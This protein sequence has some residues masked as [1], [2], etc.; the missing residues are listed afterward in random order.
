MF[1]P[2]FDGNTGRLRLRLVPGGSEFGGAEEVVIARRIQLQIADA[3][4]VYENVVEIP[5]IDVG[6]FVGQDQLQF[7]IG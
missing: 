4:V 7:G 1:T 6:Q 5:K 3:F 2:N